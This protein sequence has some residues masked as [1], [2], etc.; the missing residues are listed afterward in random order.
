[1]GEKGQATV[2]HFGR[3][4]FVAVI[5]LAL[6]VMM[7]ASTPAGAQPASQQRVLDK[8]SF[9]YKFMRVSEDSFSETFPLG[10]YLDASGDLRPLPG[11]DWIGEVAVGFT[12]E[13]DADDFD[14]SQRIMFLGGGVKREF[15]DNP[16]FTPH[17]QFLVGLANYAF[18]ASF[19]GDE[20]F[21][22]SETDFAIKIS[23]GVDWP[24]NDRWDVRGGA[25]FIFVFGEDENANIVRVFVGAVYKLG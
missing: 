15:P 25:G 22:E 5:A 3:P 2:K 12:S 16:A 11:W 13:T 8:V 24:L 4:G 20:V 17:L 7:G 19:D 18:S 6:L 21:D 23:G 9:G 1:V 14:I 10:F